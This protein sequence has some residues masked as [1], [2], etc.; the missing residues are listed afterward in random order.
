[1]PRLT[2]SLPNYRH[3]K[4]SGQ[5]VLTLGGRDYYLG[6]YNSDESKAEYNRLIGEWAANH[7]H[8]PKSSQSRAE[9]DGPA[10]SI[11][12][13]NEVLLPYLEHAESYYRKHGKPTSQMHSIRQALRVLQ[14]RYGHRPPEEVGPL[15]LKSVRAQMIELGWSRKTINKYVHIIKS[16]FKWAAENELVPGHVYHALASVSGLR[17][18]R[19]DA[20]E[21]EPVKPV[22]ESDIEAVLPHV[23]PQLRTMIELQRLTGMRPGEVVA[24]RGRDLDTTGKIWTYTP[25]SHKTEHHD[26][27]RVIYLGPKAQQVLE[28][29]LKPALEAYLF[30]PAEAEAARNEQRR[31]SRQSPLT[32]SQA[33][34]RPKKHPRRAPKAYYTEASYRRAINRA[35]DIA[36]PPPEHL[37]RQKRQTRTG[38]RLESTE[39]W[40]Q[41]LGEEQWAELKRWQREHR[42]SPNRLRHNAATYLRKEYGIEA[43]R[44][45]LGH[46]SPA[47]TEVYAELDRAKAAQIMGEVG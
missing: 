47:V 31:A 44:V 21:T 17:K 41:R 7:R 43:A 1:M 37:Q 11:H 38:L 24:M 34:R 4:A 45:I 16:V 6:P 28:P 33:K 46:S 23:T 18:G 20:R 8:A 15:A 36:F 3:H 29:W 10:E 27:Q 32:P 25:E 40:R 42:W 22:P 19:S 9:A 35:C 26:K 12:T 2:K 13:L 14:E 5:A 39:Q 30:S